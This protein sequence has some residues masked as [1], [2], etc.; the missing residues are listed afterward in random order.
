MTNLCPLLG[1][2]PTLRASFLVTLAVGDTHSLSDP[3]YSLYSACGGRQNGHQL[4]VW[5]CRG[6]GGGHVGLRSK[7]GTPVPHGMTL[8]VWLTTKAGSG[9]TEMEGSG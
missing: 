9:G 6:L 3:L 8:S 2:V 5:G 1:P 4:A 7:K